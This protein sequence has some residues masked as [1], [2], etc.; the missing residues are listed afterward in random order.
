MIHPSPLHHR[1]QAVID[2]IFHHP[3]AHNLPWDDVLTLLG[4]IGKAE[5]KHDGKWLFEVNGLQRTFHTPHGVHVDPAEV[6]KLRGF[7]SEAGVLA[8]SRGEPYL[9]GQEVAAVKM[10]VVDHHAATVYDLRD[11]TCIHVATIRPHD[12][13]HYLHHL[14]HRDQSRYRG[15]RAPEDASYYD[16]LIGALQGAEAAVLIGTATGS[17]AAIEVLGEWLRAERGRAPARIIEITHT[18]TAAYTVP[19]LAQLAHEALRAQAR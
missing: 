14:T 2:L 8:N 16:S 9:G 17:S 1:D 19:E 11:G 6:M 10:V 4:H 3:V 7:L 15:Q 18:N 13:H 5:Q 12:P